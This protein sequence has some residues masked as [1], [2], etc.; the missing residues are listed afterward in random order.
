VA[1]LAAIHLIKGKNNS[2][3][4]GILI[5]DLILGEHLNKIRESQ[6]QHNQLQVYYLTLNVQ[7]KFI[8]H[9]ADN[10]TCPFLREQENSEH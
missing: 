7:N 6:K 8:Q 2:N 1:P 3:F 10:V 4:L 5:Y 9:S